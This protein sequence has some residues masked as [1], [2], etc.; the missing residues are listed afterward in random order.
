MEKLL[1]KNIKKIINKSYLKNNFNFTYATQKYSLDIILK[2]IF[3][4]LKNGTVWRSTNCN[5]CSRNPYWNTIYKAF[6]KLSRL[7]IFEK[8]YI[9]MLKKYIKKSP[10]NKLK[11]Q[12]TDTTFIKNKYGVDKIKRNKYVN[13]KNVTKISIVCDVNGI[14]IYVNTFCGNLNDSNIL[15]QQLANNKPLIEKALMDKYS[16]HFLADKGYDSKKLRA[17]LISLNY[18]PII[19]YNKRNTKDINKIKSLTNKEKIILKKRNIIERLFGKL[20][21]SYKR[22]D[23]RYDKFII[24]Y[25]SFMYLALCSIL[26]NYL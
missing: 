15:N 18:V 17:Q 3:W 7:N 4:I 5:F 1:I 14:P 16:K 23:N 24:N 8:T 11:I 19:P 6:I 26:L 22:L 21:R 9:E 12:I 2:S 20:K 10:N 25:E 13:N